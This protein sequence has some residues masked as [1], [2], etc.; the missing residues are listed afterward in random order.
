MSLMFP[1]T[2]IDASVVANLSGGEVIVTC[3]GVVSSVTSMLAVPLPPV[4]D[5]AVAVMRFGPSARG[6]A[7]LKWPLT[8]G[9][10]TALMVTLVTLG[11]STVPVTVVGLMFR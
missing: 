8:A 4:A 2:E 3:G 1:L 7:A 11:S 5:V 9:V 10:C 6:M